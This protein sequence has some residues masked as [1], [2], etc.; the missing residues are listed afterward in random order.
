M[1]EFT[2]TTNQ[3]YVQVYFSAEENTL[4]RTLQHS[5]KQECGETV[6]KATYI[7]QHM[8][9]YSERPGV[10]MLVH[11]K[12]VSVTKFLLETKDWDLYL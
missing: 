12:V 5:S 3:L 6:L 10:I 8:P 4:I 9:C 11:V 1:T 7:K 2:H